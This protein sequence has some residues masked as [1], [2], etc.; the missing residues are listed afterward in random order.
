MPEITASE[1]DSITID[2]ILR[3]QKQ[4]PTQPLY[5]YTSVPDNTTRQLTRLPLHSLLYANGDL[6]PKAEARLA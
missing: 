1:V 3:W 5:V 4:N 2:E 6:T